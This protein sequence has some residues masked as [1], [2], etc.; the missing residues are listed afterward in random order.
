[1]VW[2][3]SGD[4]DVRAGRGVVGGGRR[5]VR[6]AGR[7]RRGRHHLPAAARARGLRA[8]PHGDRAQRARPHR[9][10]HTGM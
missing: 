1:M 7:V 6:G 5:G 9:D 8:R 2:Y 10:L 3:V 4:V